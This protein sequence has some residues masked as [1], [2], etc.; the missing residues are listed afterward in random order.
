[1]AGYNLILDTKF[2]PFSYQEML[3]PVLAATQAHQALEEE[4]GALATKASVWENM[5]NEQT[6]PFAYKTYK[7]Y[8]DELENQAGQ[9]A[10][11]GLSSLSRRK[12][13]D[14]K[15]RYAQEIAPIEN[16]YNRRKELADEQRKAL[17]QNPTLRYQRMASDMSLDDF[18]KNPMITYG[19]Q[20]S[21]NLLT[22]QV[23]QAA[24]AFQRALTDPGQ[25]TKLGLPYQYQKKIQYGA[26]PE[27][28]MQAMVKDAQQGD[29]QAV[30]FLRGITDQVLASSGVAEWADEATMREFRAFANQGLYSA[31]GQAKI[32]NFTDSYSM[33]EALERSKESRAKAQQNQA[34]RVAK[35]N[36]PI[37]IH[38]LVSPNQEGDSGAKM[39]SNLIKRLGLSSNL[40]GKYGTTVN[41]GALVTGRSDL[42]TYTFKNTDGGTT[43]KLFNSKGQFMP[44]D[45]VVKQGKSKNDQ[46]A[47]GRWYDQTWNMIRNNFTA[48]K[49]GHYSVGSLSSQM[50]AINSGNGALTMGAMRINFGSDNNKKVLESLLPQV[51]SEGSTSIYE[52]TSFTKDGR[53]N[54]GKKTELKDFQDEKGNILGTP[55]F[56]AAPNANTDGLIMKYNGKSYIIPRDK[57]GSLGEQIYNINIPALQQANLLKQDLINRYG[58]SAYYSSD[59]G[60]KVEEILNN[61][62][63][64]YLRAAGTALGYSYALPNYNIKETS[65]N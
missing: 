54:R 26:T 62:G 55:M 20:Y 61:Y 39:V 43:V 21:G 2:K 37:D 9:L 22:Q 10:R 33:Q 44:R 40:N 57:L 52:I 48:D 36:I 64:A 56:Y 46:A 16:A 42:F 12:M 47:L 23:S 38:H 4:Y 63:A 1:M 31:I 30:K 59:E 7:K 51:T 5:A 13:L 6:D 65:N 50:K 25:L 35:G 14:M 11:E 15:S 27:Q 60:M 3:A 8:A 53:I 32:D 18:I 49:Q 58:E 19:E 41:L 34:N 17:L 29:S 24:S 45:A 28:V